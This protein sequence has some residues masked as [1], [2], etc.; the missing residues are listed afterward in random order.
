MYKKGNIV[1]GAFAR[2]ND[3]KKTLGELIHD[4]N[5][6]VNYVYNSETT[7][8]YNENLQRHILQFFTEEKLL[9]EMDASE[10]TEYL[11]YLRTEKQLSNNTV[12][13]HRTHLMTL[14]EFAVQNDERYGIQINPVRKIRPLRHEPYAYKIYSPEEAKHMMSILRATQNVTLESAVAL[15][16]YCGCRREEACGL[17]WEN[18]NLR[19]EELMITEVRTVAGREVVHHKYTKNNTIRTVGIP[20]ALHSILVRLKKSQKEI[21]CD[22]VLSG[23]DGTPLHPSKISMQWHTFLQKNNLPLI[24]FHDLRHTNLSLLMSQMS[25]V[26]VAKIGGHAKVS[27]TTNIY[28]HSF[29]DTVERG[30]SVINHLL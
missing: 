29:T 26:D 19:K 25:A 22:Y 10:I 21:P 3:G 1:Y 7:W 14:F 17:R 18:V 23:K 2:H 30:R 13:K 15:A 28:G 27:T 9:E 12:N 8:R 20:A 16:L 24:R 4:W 5:Y 11:L 6:E